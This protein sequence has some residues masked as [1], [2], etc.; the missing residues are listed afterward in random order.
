MTNNRSTRRIAML[1]AAVLSVSAFA[2]CGGSA[3]SSGDTTASGSTDTGTTDAP[4]VEIGDIVGQLGFG[5]IGD[6]V[7][8][9]FCRG[10]TFTA[11]AGY[12]TEQDAGEHNKRK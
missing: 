1:L 11:R 6:S 9:L 10:L 2:S 5:S 3:V 4:E 7:G 12:S 8:Y